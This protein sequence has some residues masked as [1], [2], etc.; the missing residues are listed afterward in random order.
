MA[1]RSVS[2][3]DTYQPQV[4]TTAHRSLPFGTKL[5]VKNLANGKE[6]EVTVNDRG[7]YATGVELDL[8]KSAFS[9][10]ASTGAGIITVEYKIIPTSA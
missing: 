4:F 6:V 8:S 7:P 10:I 1:G 3:G 9:A 5:L 2:S